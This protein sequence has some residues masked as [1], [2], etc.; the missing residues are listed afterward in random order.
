MKPYVIVA[1]ILIVIGTLTLIY[2]RFTYT[3]DR[4]TAVLGP[5]SITV[6]DRETVTI[7][8]WVGLL[9]IGGGVGLLLFTWA[10]PL[11]HA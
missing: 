11:Q 8:P 5:I 9:F 1:T 10:K 3:E 2:D 7:P 4:E 6:E